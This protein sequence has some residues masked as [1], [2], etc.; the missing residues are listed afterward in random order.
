MSI[1]LRGY[2]ELA[3]QAAADT[4]AAG[5]MQRALIVLST[6]LGKTIT[7]LALAK[8][9]GG[10]TLWLAHTEELVTQPY[11]AAQ[12]VWP[13][14]SRGIVKAELNQYPRHLVFASIQ[15]AQQPQ[16]RAQLA[17]RGF[18][19]VVVDEA[20][21]ALSP[22]YRA[23]LND[24]GCFTAGGPPLLGLTAT[25]ERSDQG[26]LD[27]VF[28]GICFQMGITSAIEGGY[29]CPP[30]VVERPI[31]VDLDAVSIRRGDFG[32]KEL[33]L[34]LMKAGIVQEITAAYEEHCT[35]RKTLI[36]V[37]S[38]EQAE[39]VAAALRA[40]GHAAASV[41][42]ETTKEERASILRKLNSGEIRVLVNC[43]VLTE[44]F[45]E[46]SVDAVMLARP[47]QSKPLM[48]QMVG[49]GLRLFPAK[50]DCL[51]IDLAGV[52]KRNT[53]VQAAVLFGVRKEE[54]EEERPRA[55]DLDPFTNPEEYW[56]QRLKSQIQ[57]VKGAPRSKLRWIPA[58]EGTP[59]WLLN[60]GEYG[61]VR[62]IAAGD[63]WL[64]DVIGARNGAP[65]IQRLSEIAV[66]MDT[67]QAIAEDF[68]RRVNAVTLARKNN[69]WGEEPA[70]E[71]QVALLTRF[72]IK[73]ADQLSKQ[74]AAD[75]LTQHLSQ[76]NAEPA[77]PKQLA[78]LRA[79]G[80]DIPPNLT[81]R[82]AMRLFGA[83]K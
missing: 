66:N 69:R 55:I 43:M 19:F 25:P 62:M 20:H 34:A 11:K 51:V 77:T 80:V 81:K 13:D 37:V 42:G 45:D 28:Q 1:T 83:V 24:V 73:N 78:A 4:F 63:E 76:R 38:V 41:S 54:S 82:E 2:Q 52:S 50:T 27:E 71:K 49:R 44:G 29:L 74:T 18:R 46:P 40:R 72:G 57:G 47:T 31:K 65:A 59:G 23:L 30:T 22:G 75:L 64:V 33:D 26:A 32:Q 17:A 48:I 15:S 79:R 61:T 56:R 58:A 10:P 7:G 68:V 9:I 8:K 67:A 14:V 53:L 5:T 39:Q 16:R 36:F 3:I 12:L 35:A 21:H 70:T 60:A 6:G